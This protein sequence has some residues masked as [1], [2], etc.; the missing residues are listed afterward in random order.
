MKQTR[1]HCPYC[2]SLATLRPASVIHGLS[3]ISAGTYLYV[4]RRWPACD[5]YVTADRRTKQPLG[6]LAN[7]DLR[8]K[9][10][11]A[12]HALHSVQAQL[13]MNRDQS[14]RWLQTQMGLP[15]DQVHIA[16]CGDYRCEQIIRICEVTAMKCVKRLT[17]AQQRL[18]EENLP[19]VERVLRFDIQANP[20]VSGLGHEDLYQEGCVWLCNAA[21]TFD[22]ARGSF[23]SYA[24]R[25]VQN[26]LVGY[27]RN[28]LSKYQRTVSLG[29]LEPA[30]LAALE[31][32]NAVSSHTKCE[33]PLL[34]AAAESQYTGVTR[35]GVHALALQVS[36]MPLTAVAVRMSAPPNH[37]SAWI[38]R[39]AHKLRN[40]ESFLS[41]L[42][43]N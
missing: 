27:C 24:R 11:L 32:Q 36:G 41:S 33:T 31:A 16:K 3:D 21:L 37:V 19:I 40:N 4:C 12:H 29:D 26:G 23:A 20:C 2:G 43:E 28:A 5:A 18:V 38:S 22:P 42:H 25:V 9:R 30:V 6:T 10:I 1:I 8:H 13:G 34:L 35:R 14:Y 15:G 39:A 17:A 7:G